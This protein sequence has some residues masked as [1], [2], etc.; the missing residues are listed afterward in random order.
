MLRVAS[1]QS[2]KITVDSCPD[3]GGVWLDGGEFDQLF[4][5]GPG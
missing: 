1:A 2:R 4:E 5:A 3:C